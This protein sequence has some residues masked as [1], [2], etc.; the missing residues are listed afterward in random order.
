MATYEEMREKGFIDVDLYKIE[1]THRYGMENRFIIRKE[2]NS[3]DDVMYSK[4]RTPLVIESTEELEEGWEFKVFKI[5]TKR[6]IIIM[7]GEI[8]EWIIKFSE[9]EREYQKEKTKRSRAAK[10]EKGGYLGGKVPYGYY[11]VNKRLY[12]DDYESFVVK[13][14]F[15][16]R[17]QGCS[18][19]GIAKEL[20]LRGFRNR[21]GKEFATASV[22][23]I[24]RNKRLYQGYITF[25]GKEIKGQFK[26]ILE[27]TE[28]LLTEEW[29]NRV[30]SSSIEA[31][32]NEHRKRH[33]SENSGPKEIKPYILVGTEPKK[34]ARR[35]R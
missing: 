20:T 6:E 5:L 9:K 17:S 18:L 13:F 28:S 2:Y 21:S 30:F 33:Y 19:G 15:Y 34:K 24:L 23:S 7:E 8:P 22:D 3:L 26:G 12:I 31:R 29:K 35:L 4:E 10:G 25:E 1:G 11:T 27:D 16:R 32:L 14:V